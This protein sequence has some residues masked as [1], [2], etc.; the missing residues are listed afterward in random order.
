MYIPTWFLLVF[1]VIGFYIYLKTGRN[2]KTQIK[3]KDL[4]SLYSYQLDIHIEPN[5][6][7]LYR[8]LHKDKTDEE[9]EEF[10]KH[11][12]FASGKKEK[13]GLWGQ[14]FFFTEYY[15]SSTGLTT[16]LQRIV[17]Q[18]GGQR[19]FPVDKF[20]SAGYI[21]DSDK[22]KFDRNETD[23][24]RRKRDELTVEIGE[25]FIRNDIF[26]HLI[27]GLKNDF[28]Y[29]EDNY[30]FRFPLRDV[31]NFL[32]S[33][34]QRFH[35]L[36]ECTVLKW[37]DHIEDKFKQFGIKYDKFLE[38]EPPIFDLEKQ[39][40][41]F[42]ERIGRPKVSSSDQRDSTFLKD[43]I[44]THYGIRLKLFRPDENPRISGNLNICSRDK[45]TS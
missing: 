10:F 21:L 26:E 43:E 30:P 37:P 28:E 33:L 8:A 39:D 23:E 12:P 14:R 17:D 13:E 18:E 15:D 24:D 36:E 20:G 16:K 38:F 2:L 4:S 22:E 27:G 29:T 1:L 9:F 7:G 11:N 6:Y 34:G 44:G 25:D 35:G 45:T 41:D 3:Q 40:Q 32:F 19:F 42:F 31:F 5:W